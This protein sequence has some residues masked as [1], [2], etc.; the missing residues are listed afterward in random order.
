MNT[1]GRIG[2]ETI[3]IVEK[4]VEKLANS[5]TQD[6]GLELVDI[7]YKS[8]R[9]QPHLTV[10]IDKPG[11]VSLEDCEKVS[12]SLGELLDGEDPIPYRYIL[13]V[14][15][16]GPARSLKKAADFRRFQGHDV[17]IKTYEKMNGRRNFKGVLKNFQEDFIII[18]TNEGEQIRIGL[19]EVAKANLYEKNRG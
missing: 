7:E 3:N 11:G 4:T 16:P 6:L 12:K 15:S 2:K 18:E 13:E 19:K 1:P 8:L 14:S 17:Q 9:R 10:Y 5:V